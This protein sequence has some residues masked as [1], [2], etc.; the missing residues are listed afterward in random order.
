VAGLDFGGET[1]DG[2]CDEGGN[3][4]PIRALVSWTN[5][6]IALQRARYVFPG[7]V[8]VIDDSARTCRLCCGSRDN[9]FTVYRYLEEHAEE[10]CLLPQMAGGK[11]DVY[12]IYHDFD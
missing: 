12:V 2:W 7:M 4:D 3:P 1:L 9:A 5:D 6:V 11:E 10:M 8:A